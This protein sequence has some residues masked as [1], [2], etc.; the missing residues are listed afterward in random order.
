ML[1]KLIIARN[2]LSFLNVHLINHLIICLD[3]RFINSTFVFLIV[4][5]IL[6]SQLNLIYL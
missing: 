2:Q 5:K 1:L 3:L 4:I 6:F